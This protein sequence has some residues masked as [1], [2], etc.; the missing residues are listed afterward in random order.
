MR[1]ARASVC[2]SVY[3]HARVSSSRLLFFWCCRLVAAVIVVV[4]FVYAVEGIQCA[5][6][7]KS[8]EKESFFPFDSTFISNPL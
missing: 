5:Q 8:V 7:D 6:S 2:V 4:I 3:L 1:S